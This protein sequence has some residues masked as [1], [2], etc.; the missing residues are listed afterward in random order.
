MLR[1][2]QSAVGWVAVTFA[3]IAAARVQVLAQEPVAVISIKN[4]DSLISDLKYILSAGGSPELSD[5]VDNMIEQATQG[6]G[7]AGIDRTKPLGAY[8]TLNAGNSPDFVFFVPV[9]DNRAFR[10]DFLSALFPRQ[11]DVAGGVFSVQSEGQ[12][13][14]GKFANGHC[15][16]TALPAA[17]YKLA[18]PARIVRSKFTFNLEADL[19]RMPDEVKDGLVEQ[20]EEAVRAAEEEQANEPVSEVEARL[21]D[22][23]QKMT[24]E[25]ARMLFKETD[26]L[27]LGIDVDQQEKLVAL[28]IGLVAKPNSSF[29]K[30]LATYSKTASAY[31][32]I[33]RPD[34]AASV[35]FAAPLSDQMR[36][37]L[38]D[39]IE[40]NMEQARTD[41]DNSEK[42]KTPQQK[43]AAKDLLERIM[44][45]VKAT[46]KT[47]LIDGALAIYPT[48]DN[49]AQVV[50]GGR[51]ASGADFNKTLSEFV[52]QHAG[53]PEADR[54]KLDV[55]QYSDARVHEVTL[56][57]DE[58]SE[59]YLSSGTMH[60]AVRGD[61][62]YFAIGGDTLAALKAAIDSIGKSS[63]SNRPPVSVRIQPSK[64]VTIFG[65]G[66]DPNV[67]LARE[68]FT[69]DGDHI[70][71]ELFSVQQGARLR[72]ELGEG[73]LRFIALSISQQ[74]EE[75]PEPN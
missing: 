75:E 4:A 39:S 50:G 56:E 9:T 59:T 14:Y 48:K 49:M 40:S 1:I 54:I 6:R 52:R 36:D 67:E 13:Y 34:A 64:I 26:R 44:Q 46:G 42:L 18:D 38:R 63:S 20:A 22:R 24:A 30:S 25:L 73:F 62:A 57:L 27:S 17:L 58:E 70:S 15:F 45:I 37:Y 8:M 21:R 61:A 65:K 11:Q 53:T 7:L 71:L 16:L 2:R 55:A 12:Q 69:G 19:A 32:S 72:L 74:L 28:D 60:L 47:G 66:D 29:A 35:I 43:E 10:E 5:L 51:I 3:F 31:A 23:G 68:A 41:I 33:I